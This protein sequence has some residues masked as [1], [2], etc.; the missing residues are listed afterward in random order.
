VSWRLP[1]AALL[2]ATSAARAA[3]VSPAVEALRAQVMGVSNEH[4]AGGAMVAFTSDGSIRYLGTARGRALPA[5]VGTSASER[6]RGFLLAH[7]DAFGFGPGVD[8]ALE[9]AQT[10][11]DRSYHRFQQTLNGI[12][13]IGGEAVV[14]LD[15]GAGVQA[16]MNRTA[17]GPLLA[18]IAA[19]PALSPDAASARA[20][21]AA[22]PE[23]EPVTLEAPRLAVFVPALFEGSGPARLAW[24][25]RVHGGLDR[26]NEDLVLDAVSG[27]VIWRFSLDADALNRI[28][29]DANSGRDR[30]F[31][32]VRNEGGAACGIADA[33]NTYDYLGDTYNFY[34]NNHGRDSYDN[35][36]GVLHGV[37]RY[38]GFP[39]NGG[40]QCGNA[41]FTSS[42]TMYVG[43]GFA[44]DDVIGHEV[45]HGVTNATSQLAYQNASGAMNESMSD[46]WGEYIDQ[47]NGRGTDT[48]DVKWEVGE[49]LPGGALRSMK[50]PTSSASGA[51]P[52]KLSSPNYVPPTNSPNVGN[53]FGGVHTNSGVGNKLCYLLTDGDTFNKQTVTGM[54]F[55]VIYLYYEAQVHLLTSS[56]G[57]TDLYFALR[58]A[59]LN[60][61]W[62]SSDLDNI[63]RACQAV[64]IT[65]SAWADP[66]ASCGEAGVSTCQPF[67]GGPYHSLT[68]AVNGVYPGTTIFLYAGTFHETLPMTISKIMTITSTGGT[69][70]VGP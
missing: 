23:G 47:N 49:D 35:A 38:C 14:Q 9:K 13:V 62:S 4:A 58:Q 31:T 59:A 22:A 2:L 55:R 63:V 5:P 29:D 1:V 57:W 56:S 11:R 45:T 65:P 66:L 44:V 50:D 26:R 68:S 16:V 33:D 70:S 28:I 10:S 48:P 46:I 51:Q 67:V 12:P 60:L 64:E 32:N 21:A 30:P 3:E 61:G 37:V 42:D 19:R 53:D 34:L 20:R 27:A 43:P 39:Q 15:T 69:A 17:G 54:G 40:T 41:Q 18:G 7:G 36:G 24:E 25:V 52:D 6:A 8:L